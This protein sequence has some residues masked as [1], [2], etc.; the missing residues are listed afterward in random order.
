[1]SSTLILRFFREP[2]WYEQLYH[3]GPILLVALILLVLI[4]SDRKSAGR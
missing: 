4:F 1:M 3:Y 2:P